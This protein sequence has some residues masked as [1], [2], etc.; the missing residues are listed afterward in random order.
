[1]P[2]LCTNP[3]ISAVALAKCPRNCGLCNQP[4]AGGRC[5]DTSPNCAV[6]VALAGC[7]DT[8][9]QQMCMGTC[10]IKTCLSTTGGP[11]VQICSDDRANCAQMQRYCT[12]EPFTGTLRQ[13]CR[14]T[15]RVC[16]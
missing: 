8:N 11:S 13:Q 6:L 9:I 15:C 10:N 16:T 7:N 1:M 5:P 2:Q 3:N 4:G 14:K 12:I